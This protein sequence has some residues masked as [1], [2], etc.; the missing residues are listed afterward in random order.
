M[1][2]HQAVVRSI[3]ALSAGLAL[4]GCKEATTAEV[5]GYEPALLEAVPGTE[6]KRVS[7]TEE[8]LHRI[9]LQTASVRTIAGQTAV[10]HAAIIYEA[11][12]NTIVYVAETPRSFMR[13]PVVVGRVAGDWALIRRGPAEGTAVVTVGAAQ[14]HGAE[15]EIAGGH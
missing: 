10:P 14:V 15:L 11:D 3:V 1:M 5:T 12:G 8:A 9:D 7:F 6:A 13:R 4:T 2:L